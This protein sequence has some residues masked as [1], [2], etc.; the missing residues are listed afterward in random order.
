MLNLRSGWNEFMAS[1]AGSRFREHYDRVHRQQQRSRWRRM[2]YYLLSLLCILIG[3][4]LIIIPGPAMLFFL[5]A[6]ILLSSESRSL[7]S[8][9]DTVEARVRSGIAR[10]KP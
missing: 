2:I 4:V 5:I 8:L 10:F 1:T 3:T 7:A 6:A 9:L